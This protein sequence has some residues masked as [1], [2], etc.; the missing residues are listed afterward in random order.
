VL[1]DVAKAFN[2]EAFGDGVTEGNGMTDTQRARGVFDAEGN[3]NFGVTR[4]AGTQLAEILEVIHVELTQQGKF[5]IKKSGHMTGVHKEAVAGFP[6]RI[7]RVESQKFCEKKGNCV[8]GTHGSTRVTGLCLLHHGSGKDS[9]V[10]SR[11]RNQPIFHF[12][13][14]SL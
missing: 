10:V 9:N 13:N 14:L 11:F 2:H 7:F 5:T 4:S 8:C 6:I 3:I 12:F 1:Q